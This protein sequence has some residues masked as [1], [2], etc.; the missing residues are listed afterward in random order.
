MALE[1]YPTNL[2]VAM[3]TGFGH[4]PQPSTQRTQM[5]LGTARVRQVELG[6]KP[7]NVPQRF[8][9]TG[10]EVREF[11]AWIE[12]QLNKGADWFTMSIYKD[13]AFSTE[14]CRLIGL[15][16]YRLIAHDLWR[17]DVQVEVRTNLY[18]AG[19]ESLIP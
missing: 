16:R 4:D 13:D 15:P 6:V 9:Y 7:T 5:T 1:V 3:R 12:V 17:V 10:D 14:E 19:D 2:P 18:K 11:R 8:E